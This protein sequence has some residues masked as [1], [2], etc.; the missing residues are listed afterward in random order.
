[1]SSTPTLLPDEPS[2]VDDLG[3]AHAKIAETI[4]TL[5]RTSPGGRTIRLDGTWGSGKSTVIKMIA[6]RLENTPTGD[7]QDSGTVASDFA[8]FQYDAW[9]HSGDPLRRAF[10]CALVTTTFKKGWLKQS[11]GPADYTF[12]S[13]RLDRLSRKLKTTSRKTT[14]VFSTMA[15][16]VLSGLMALGVVAPMAAELERKLTEKLG[17]LPLSA[18]ILTAALV[19]FG[20]IHWLTDETMG[21]IVRRASDEETIE[22]RDEPEPTSIEFQEAFGEL[23]ESLLSWPARRLLIVIDNLDRIDQSETQAVW[24]LLRSFLDNPNFTS[25]PWFQRLWVIVPVAEERNV[26]AQTSS[27]EASVA[28]SNR[29]SKP[30]FLEKVFQVRFSVPP[31]MLHSWKNFFS[32]KLNA[33]FGSDLTGDY[34]EIL[35]L[36]ED[37]EMRPDGPLTPRGIVSFINELVVLRLEWKDEVSLSC[38][39]AYLLSRPKLSDVNC[40]PP[41]AVTRILKDANLADTFS[42]LHLRASTRKEASYLSLRPKLEHAL[43]SA[44]TEALVQLSH[45]SPG[46][47]YVLDRFIRQDLRSLDAQQERLL[48]ALRALAP[49]VLPTTS[50]KEGLRP[51]SAGT[52]AHL[53][54]VAFSTMSAGGS[55]RL[56]NANLVPGLSAFLDIVADRS[57]G[58][59][60]IVEM[61]RNIHR[62]NKADTSHFDKQ[63]IQ[64]WNEWASTLGDVLSMP[65]VKGA[66]ETS[67]F[68]PITLPIGPALWAYLC[69]DFS[70]EPRSWILD[71]CECSDGPL[72]RLEWLKEQF[73]SAEPGREHLAA[74]EQAIRS[75]NA[76]WFEAVAEA[77]RQRLTTAMNHSVDYVCNVAV[78]LLRIDRLRWK[79][80]LLELADDGT[81]LHYFGVAAGTSNSD[82]ALA[83]LAFLVLFATNGNPKVVMSGTEADK[84]KALDGLKIL[85]KMIEGSVG[86]NGSQIRTYADELMDLELYDVLTPLTNQQNPSGLAASL[87]FTLGHSE[88]FFSYIAAQGHVKTE[89]IAFAGKYIHSESLRKQFVDAVLRK[90]IS[91]APAML[92]I[93][94]NK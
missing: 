81:L 84:P 72:S 73:T 78:A 6:H 11:D 91:T 69:R 24:A 68:A 2:L 66:I 18:L 63:I 48:Q 80:Y 83:T 92:R 46:F 94:E 79:P 55:L 36:Y 67:G 12:W 7:N 37:E 31:P 27:L 42:M 26:L 33:T 44:D 10:L 14:P 90:E 19:A 40:N 32:S 8:V 85:K 4:A 82:A 22:T 9:V 64:D 39:A 25:Q 60:L 30:S 53:Q 65:E 21:F 71:R 28:G 49:L 56:L 15:K 1:M 47:E 57:A 61:V 74:L 13:K 5:V 88:R 77:V 87:V 23:M 75:G 41:A 89:I 38:L 86:L 70:T 34:D 50:S 54:T 45:E 20:L 93:V 51:L 35:R 76:S 29:A 52:V 3:G 58:A 59:D 62:L 16:V 43:D 17:S